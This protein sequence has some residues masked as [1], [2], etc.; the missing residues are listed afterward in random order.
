MDKNLG[1]KDV[2]FIEGKVRHDWQDVIAVKIESVEFSELDGII[3]IVPSFLG[4]IFLVGIIEASAIE[5]PA[6]NNVLL[7]MGF[8]VESMKSHF[9]EIRELG[10]NFGHQEPVICFLFLCLFLVFLW[11]ALLK[12]NTKFRSSLTFEIEFWFLLFKPFFLLFFL[13]PYFLIFTAQDK[14]LFFIQH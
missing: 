6:R 7:V 4:H 8:F 5:K 13:S 9:V 10:V 14:L 11:G 12:V 3:E 2:F 1:C